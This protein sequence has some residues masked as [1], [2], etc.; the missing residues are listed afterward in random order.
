MSLNGTIAITSSSVL[1]PMLSPGQC[2]R[3]PLPTI[4]DKIM[5]ES[6]GGTLKHNEKR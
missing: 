4:I 5:A 3:N 6:I 1:V 2:T